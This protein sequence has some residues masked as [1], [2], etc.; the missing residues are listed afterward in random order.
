MQLISLQCVRAQIHWVPS[1]DSPGVFSA[2]DQIIEEGAVQW[3]AL[4]LL[5]QQGVVGPCD[6]E[7]VCDV[8]RSGGED[9]YRLNDNRVL[10]WLVCKAGQAQHALS[11]Q[12]AGM[13]PLDQHTY[14]CDFLAEYLAPKWAVM[15]RKHFNVPEDNPSQGGRPAD[16]SHG[17]QSATKRLKLDPKEAAREMA[18]KRAQQARLEDAAKQASGTKKLTAFFTPKAKRSK[19]TKAEQAAEPTQPTKAAKAKPAPQ[20]GRSL[21]RDCN[22]ALNMQRI[23]ESRWRPL[24]LCYWLEQGKLPTKGKEYPGL[25]YKRVRDKPS[26]AKQQQQQQQPA[27]AQ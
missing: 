6:L 8:K 11:A 21:D 23:G 18:R 24:E 9:Y 15:L 5:L 14:C 19:C 16:S 27:A 25:G 2:L 4:P 3:P 17:E 10:A 22:A 7:C 13:S 20:P 26:K 1:N 12:L